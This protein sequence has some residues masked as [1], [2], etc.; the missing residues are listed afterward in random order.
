MSYFQEE[1]IDVEDVEEKK[2]AEFHPSDAKKAKTDFCS[3]DSASLPGI[4]VDSNAPPVGFEPGM[5]KQDDD[6]LKVKSDGQSKAKKKRKDKK[7]HKHKHKHRHSKEK[8]KEKKESN[9]V[10]LQE[11]VKE[12][13]P[14]TL[15]S[16]D[17]SSNSTTGQLDLTM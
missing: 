3:D 9:L 13:T 4:L 10:K 1:I 11:Q 8:S 15:S 16:A 17:S 7:K 5:F 2:V 12:E 6:G 14:E